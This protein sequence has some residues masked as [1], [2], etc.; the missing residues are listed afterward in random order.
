VKADL[1]QTISPMGVVSGLVNQPNQ[2]AED[3]VNEIMTRAVA[4]LQ[5]SQKTLS[6][7]NAAK[8]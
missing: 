1:T 7:H 5:A 2:S 3:I 4:V 8:L 6:R